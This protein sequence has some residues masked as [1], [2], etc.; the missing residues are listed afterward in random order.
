M[1][2]QPLIFFLLLP[3]E[4]S[5]ESLPNVTHCLQSLLYSN[6]TIWMLLRKQYPRR[7]RSSSSG[8]SSQDLEERTNQ[9]AKRIE[10]EMI[11]VV[12]SW[13]SEQQ[14][15]L[16]ELVNLMKEEK[17]SDS[18]EESGFIQ[19]VPVMLQNGEK[20][21]LS[22]SVQ[23]NMHC[24]TQEE[25]SDVL[26]EM[27]IPVPTSQLLRK[28]RSDLLL[29]IFYSIFIKM[30][31]LVYSNSVYKLAAIFDT[32]TRMARIAGIEYYGIPYYTESLFLHN[33]ILLPTAEYSTDTN[34]SFFACVYCSNSAV[35][36]WHCCSN[37]NI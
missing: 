26:S 10:E 23:V 13:L 3:L 22:E 31:I 25:K 15:E 5:P 7:L 4:I 32:L 34:A 8:D 28:L 12:R 16:L 11:N 33:D 27:L 20:Y 9:I 6:S 2:R 29:H 21:G 35:K 19:D 14:P 17:P 18:G 37:H 30:N 36:K 1:V 24:V